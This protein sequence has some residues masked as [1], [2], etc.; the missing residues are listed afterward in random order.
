MA[1]SVPNNS[2]GAAAASIGS[3]IMMS[4][5]SQCESR[6]TEPLPVYGLYAAKAVAG[7]R[8]MQRFRLN[9]VLVS[10]RQD[11]P[12]SQPDQVLSGT[13]EEGDDKGGVSESGM[14]LSMARPDA[15]PPPSPIASRAAS[16]PMRPPCPA[17]RLSCSFDDSICLT[18]IITH[19]SHT[20]S[21]P[22]AHRWVCAST[23]TAPSARRTSWLAGW[24]PRCLR[25]CVPAC[26]RACLSTTA[27]S[28]NGRSWPLPGTEKALPAQQG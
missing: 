8:W 25:A 24:L 22:H 14:W 16:S 21:T 19:T 6:S 27:R 3:A 9:D 17:L 11:Q 15:Y 13:K 5:S 1:E 26:L 28:S 12:A 2:A 7:W 18:S 10:S 20:M 4:C 23:G